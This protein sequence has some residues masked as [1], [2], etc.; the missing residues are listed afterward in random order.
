VANLDYGVPNSIPRKTVTAFLKHI[1]LDPSRCTSIE[2]SVN[3]I[4]AEMFALDPEG[5]KYVEFD[6]IAKHRI[7][8]PFE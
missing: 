1:G 7:F 6:E 8:V 4:Y 5:R 3:G 2:L